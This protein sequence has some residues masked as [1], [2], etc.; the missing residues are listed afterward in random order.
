MKLLTTEMP[1]WPA[2]IMVC[3]AIDSSRILKLNG[4]KRP[5]YLKTCIDQEWHQFVVMHFQEDTNQRNVIRNA[6][7]N[8]CI[9]TGIYLFTTTA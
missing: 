1:E 3:S 4:F 2:I 8:S 5:V 9:N 7:N 6:S